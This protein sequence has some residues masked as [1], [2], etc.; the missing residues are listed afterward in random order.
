[1]ALWTKY[2]K[3]ERK[4][5]QKARARGREDLTKAEVAGAAGVV[6]RLAGAEERAKGRKAERKLKRE[7][8][9]IEASRFADRAGI[10]RER[11]AMGERLGEAEADIGE[12]KLGMARSDVRHM[13]RLAPYVYGLGAAQ[14]GTAWYQRQKQ[15]ERD[16]ILDERLGEILGRRGGVTPPPTPRSDINYSL[17][18]PTGEQGYNPPRR[19]TPVDFGRGNYALN[20]PWRR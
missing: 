9:D 8:L 12:R 10:A 1:M 6:G 19:R 15:A 17:N 20:L 16:R 3:R 18:L 11:I 14:I 2:F 5:E 7:A 4:A 13:K